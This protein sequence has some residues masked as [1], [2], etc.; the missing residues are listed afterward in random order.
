MTARPVSNPEPVT[1]PDGRSLAW[2]EYGDPSGRPVLFFHGGPGSRLPLLP[3]QGEAAASSGVRLL[4]VERPGFGESTRHPS[5]TLLGWADDVAAFA[6][7]LE[8]GRFAVIGY[9]AG[10]P[11]ALACAAKPGAR[12][13]RAVAVGC[14][15]PWNLPELTRRMDWQ[16]R[17][18]RFLAMRAPWLLRLTYRGLP[19]PGRHPEKLV[20]K[21]LAGL[22]KPDRE[23]LGREELFRLGTE[24]TIAGVIHGFDGMADEVLLLARPWGFDLESIAA[25]VTLWCGTEDTAAPPCQAEHLASRIPGARLH[26][27][28]GEGHL[29][30]LERWPEILESALQR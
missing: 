2:A 27:L 14:G 6:S 19:D 11:H 20:R 5:R 1:L 18:L 30:I 8:L 13:D 23:L 4:C 9:S 21:M 7:A 28:E 22:S 16:R 3:G 26:L 15:V 29:C 12:L 24:H 25:P 10:G 17:T